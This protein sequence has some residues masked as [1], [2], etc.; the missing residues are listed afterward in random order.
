[1]L[2]AIP[3]HFVRG[4][5]WRAFKELS[6]V[7]DPRLSPEKRRISTAGRFTTYIRLFSD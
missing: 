4:I 7:T 5:G 1:M 6:V 2:I 3:Y